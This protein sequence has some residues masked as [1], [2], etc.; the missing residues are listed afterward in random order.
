MFY[1][2]MENVASLRYYIGKK[3]SFISAGSA[4][5]DRWMWS[6]DIWGKLDNLCT[7]KRAQRCTAPQK[8]E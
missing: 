4:E 1:W 5:T 3:Y 7:Q 2:E 8:L 6:F